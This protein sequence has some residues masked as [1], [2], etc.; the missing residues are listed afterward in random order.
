MTISYIIN[1]FLYALISKIKTTAVY[2]HCP[3]LDTKDGYKDFM[4][5]NELLLDFFSAH[6][7]PGFLC[8]FLKNSRY[9]EGLEP[10][11]SF[12][13]IN[14]WMSLLQISFVFIALFPDRVDAEKTVCCN[15]LMQNI[16]NVALHVGFFLMPFLVIIFN[17]G[18]IFLND[19]NTIEPLMLLIFWEQVILVIWEA[20]GIYGALVGELAN[21]VNDDQTGYEVIAK[22]GH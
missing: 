14:C 1:A 6:C 17:L 10:I 19:L 2:I 7:V 15:N 22:R 8:F 3:T 5:V 21:E 12:C 18:S 13:T 4:T 9:V 11:Q 20:A 16:I